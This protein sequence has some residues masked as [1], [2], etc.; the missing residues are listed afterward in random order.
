MRK[1]VSVK[2]GKGP[3][4]AGFFAGLVFC[5]L[6]LFVIVPVFGP[7]GIVWTLFAVIITIINGYNAFSNKGIAS[8]EIMIEDVSTGDSL[9]NEKTAEE[10]L[11][12]LQSLYEKGMITYAEYQEKRS[13]ILSEI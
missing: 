8:H 12:E 13:R 10:R 6:G 11:K 4:A 7:F 1:R 9:N 5:F 3:S 2:P